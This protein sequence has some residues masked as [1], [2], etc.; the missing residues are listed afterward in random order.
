MFSDSTFFIRPVLVGFVP[1]LVIW[2]V[3]FQAALKLA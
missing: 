2:G 1:S 3:F